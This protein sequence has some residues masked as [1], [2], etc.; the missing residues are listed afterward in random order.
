MVALLFLVSLANGITVFVYT[1]V[2]KYWLALKRLG[3]LLHYT[4][5]NYLDKSVGCRVIFIPLLLL[6]YVP[7]Y[8]CMIPFCEFGNNA[9]YYDIESIYP[10]TDR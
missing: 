7:K 5:I 9:T 10:D 6:G 1:F 8:R 4:T 2:G 3:N